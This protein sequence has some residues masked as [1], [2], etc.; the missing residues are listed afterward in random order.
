MKKI[1]FI[2]IVAISGLLYSC[3]KWDVVK[4]VGG[5]LT[6]EVLNVEITFDYNE[7]EITVFNQNWNGARVIISRRESWSEYLDIYDRY[8]LGRGTDTSTAYFESGDKIKVKIKTKN[9]QGDEIIRESFFEL[10]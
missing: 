7:E 2:L 10:G 6:V 9:D 1:L 5:Q 4:P 3:S 8:I